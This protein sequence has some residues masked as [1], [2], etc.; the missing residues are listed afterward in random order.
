MNIPFGVEIIYQTHADKNCQ[1]GV[2]RYDMAKNNRLLEL[3][4]VIRTLPAPITAARLAQ[5]LGTTTRTIYRY[6][7]DLRAAG[8]VIDGAAGYGYSLVEDPAMPPMIFDTDEIEALVL[9]LRE[10]QQIG[11]P[12]LAKAAANVLSKVNASLPARTQT[13]LQNAVLH[14]KR[15][16]PRPKIK[17]DVA[18]LRQAAREEWV[19]EI[20]YADAQG[21]AST[22]HVQPLSIVFMDDKLILLAFCLLRKDS[23]AFRVDRI[24]MLSVTDQSFRPKRVGLLREAL[25][26]IKRE[27]TEVISSNSQLRVK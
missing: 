24:K 23:R 15:F 9:G 17:I 16:R 8:A 11:D 5:E 20:A 12:V 19:I 7:D 27:T 26:K 4:Q 1:Y 3:M 10:V 25:A 18:A 6:I 14:A 13:Y 2:Q 22:R 21:V